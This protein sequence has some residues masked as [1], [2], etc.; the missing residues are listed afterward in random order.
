MDYLLDTNIVLNLIRDSPLS[1][2][3]RTDY[4]IFLPPRR[5]F[6]SVVV[7]GEL[8]SLAL[9][10]EW[11]AAKHLLLS[12]YL[13]NLIIVDI[14]VNDIIKRY[15]EIDAYSQGKLKSLR[16]TG[17]ARNMGKNDLWIAATASILNVPL[18]TTDHDFTH[19]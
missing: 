14:R 1:K 18:M 11:G 16:L 15:A 5:L 4:Q 7:E 2:Q 9:Q 13:S 10:N 12:H 8:E 19:L 3:I 17:S 6:T